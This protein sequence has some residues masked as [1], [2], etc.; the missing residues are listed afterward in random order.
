MGSGAK[1]TRGRGPVTLLKYFKRFTKSEALKLEH[2]IKKLS[3]EDKLSFI[4]A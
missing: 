3:K 4:D 1:Y 2:Q